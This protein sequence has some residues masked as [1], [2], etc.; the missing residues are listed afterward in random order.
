M[1]ETSTRLRDLSESL[2]GAKRQPQA[3]KSTP[4]S[5][6]KQVSPVTHRYREEMSFFD[7]AQDDE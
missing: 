6:A 1:T 3:K 5:E 2:V 7:C 4:E